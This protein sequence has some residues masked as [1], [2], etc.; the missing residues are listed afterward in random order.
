MQDQEYTV[1]NVTAFVTILSSLNDV[2]AQH[3]LVVCIVALPGCCLHA[4]ASCQLPASHQWG[5]VAVG[6]W[7][8][9]R[10]KGN[11]LVQLQVPNV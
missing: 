4:Y 3:W 1:C 10:S 8:P 7:T 5:S 6:R 2:P 11:G 9:E